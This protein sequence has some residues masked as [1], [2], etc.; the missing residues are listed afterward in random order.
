M[1]LLKPYKLNQGDTIGV[2]TPST[3]AYKYNEE[4]FLNGM[5]NIEAL[6]F[7][8]KLGFL[9]GDRAS[10]GYRSGT[11]QDRAKE[12]MDLIVDDEVS[13]V[14]STIGG[15]NSSSMIPYLD[16]D[17]IREKR[18]IFCGYSDVTS[19]H[20]AILKY[21]GLK[22]LYGTAAMVWFGEYPD[23]ERETIES[24]LTA[25]TDNSN[26]ERELKPFPR[27]SNHFRDWANG[28]WKNKDREWKEN[29]G[30][31]ALRPGSATAEIVVANLNTLM[32]TAGTEFFPDLEGK[33]LLIE[34]MDA[35]MAEEER[36]L[37]HL[38]LL[39]GFDKI[40]GLIMSKP[41]TY[42][43]GGAPFELDDLLMEIV[44]ERDY[45]IITEFD[46]SHTVPM[47]AIGERCKISINAGEGYDV[48]FKLLESF[49][50]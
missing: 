39:G 8:V 45:P 33:I 44:G 43:N 36:D 28:D 2:F 50:E 3:P 9:T 23:G 34:E 14:L 48:N 15:A 42:S 20:M 32:T 47:H 24:F 46:C 16:Y 29:K 18:K 7:K 10:Q 26:L 5:K 4:M 38:Q 49:V 27:W 41:E 22:T 31:K 12:F 37:R 17:L 19:L 1:N 40:S 6:G 25:V 21:S 35:P 11:P 13:A 30:W